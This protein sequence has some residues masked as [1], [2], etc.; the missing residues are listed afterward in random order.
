VNG[1]VP[2]VVPALRAGDNG[3]QMNIGMGK[4]GKGIERGQTMQ[5][6]IPTAQECP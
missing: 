5:E 3:N 4:V 2:N 1:F 6:A